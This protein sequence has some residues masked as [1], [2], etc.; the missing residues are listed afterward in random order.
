MQFYLP[1]D[2]TRQTLRRYIYNDYTTTLI[3]GKLA[4]ENG[5]TG[6]QF[7]LPFTEILAITTSRALRCTICNPDG[8]PPSQ[9]GV[10]I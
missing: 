6:V 1:L 4:T 7:K 10:I 9:A 3:D 8:N 5:Y 2:P